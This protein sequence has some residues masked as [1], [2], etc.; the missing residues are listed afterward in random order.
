MFILNTWQVIIISSNISCTSLVYY[1]IIYNPKRISLTW[2]T[3][4]LVDVPKLSR[5]PLKNYS[6]LSPYIYTILQIEKN[7]PKTVPLGRDWLEM[8]SPLE[9]EKI[10]VKEED[11][12][13]RGDSKLSPHIRNMSLAIWAIVNGM[14]KMHRIVVMCDISKLIVHYYKDSLTR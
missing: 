6:H 13:F 10:E 7:S 11:D 9:R 8:S 2:S 3:L 4:T 1:T 5:Y 14:G 12:K